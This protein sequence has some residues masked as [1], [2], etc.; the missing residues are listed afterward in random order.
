M[1]EVWRESDLSFL[2]VV[3]FI[4]I[5]IYIYL[6]LVHYW[7]ILFMRF[8]LNDGIELKLLRLRIPLREKGGS[9]LKRLMII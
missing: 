6:I 5:Y 9:S 3:F 8:C 1:D 4:Y 7:G 2:P